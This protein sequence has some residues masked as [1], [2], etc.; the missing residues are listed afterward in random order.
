MNEGNK[1]INVCISC[2]NNYAKY[3]GIVITSVLANASDDDSLSFY[4]LDG[5]IDNENIE[6]I[7][8]LKKIKECN[9]NFIQIDESI[10]E[11]FKKLTTH[12]YIS[13]AAYFR[14][15]LPSLLPNIDKIIY[16]DCDVI[17]NTSLRNLYNTV[18]NDCP[19]AGVVDIKKKIVRVNPGYV[20]SGV[21][22][23]DLNKM[24]EL[25]LENKFYEYAKQN[26]EHIKC[27]D[28]EVI[29]A[30]CKGDIKILDNKWNVQ[31]S[32]FTNRSDYMKNPYIVH[33]V[34]KNKPWQ[35]GSYSYKKELFFTYLQKSPWKIDKK[36]YIKQRYIGEIVSW[37]RYLKY[38]P[39]FMFRPKFYY[40]LYKTYMPQISFY[41]KP[42]IKDNTFLVWEPCGKSHAEVVPGFVKYLLDLGYHVSVLVSPNAYKEKLFARFNKNENIS[43]N[44]MSQR[45]TRRYFKKSDLNNVKGVLVTTVGKLCTAPYYEQVDQTFNPKTDRSKLF[46]VEHEIDE[47]VDRNCLPES[48]ITL[49]KM[50][51]KDAKTVVVNPHYFGEI[52][53][54]PK[55]DLTNFVAVGEL[56]AGK[57]NTTVFIETAQKLIQN[58]ITNFKITVVGKGKIEDLPKDVAQYFD[59]KGRLPFDKMF[60]EIEKGDFLLSA[61]EDIPGHIRYITTGTS[62]NFQLVY[63]FIKPIIIKENFAPINGFN[64]R[65]SILYK[66]DEDFYNAMVKAIKMSADD[67]QS[68]QNDLKNYA[69]NFYNESRENLKNLI[70][71]QKGDL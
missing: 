10:F 2:D 18:M 33:F 9:I 1:D 24:R 49:R 31:I 6:K 68:M 8:S 63:G 41:K 27:G 36:E 17:V 58:G 43:Y 39:L 34:S 38:R 62:G 13:V 30:V 61:Y 32:N 23:M 64:D 60:D 53:I 21:L 16:F 45:Q 3:A 14:L 40:A 48:M 5:G 70:I 26:F 25:S 11:D 37:L 57:K 54:T 7:L 67:Y 46:Y 65:N 71:S 42:V 55:H 50:D 69:D 22:V 47:R 44:K 20:N 29:N 66:D 28:Q 35:F 19:I 51:Y 59:I 56:K 15:K 52:K 4:I 12:K